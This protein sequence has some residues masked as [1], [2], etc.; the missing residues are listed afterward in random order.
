LG[1]DLSRTGAR[2][3]RE[4]LLGAV[5]RIDGGGRIGK[6]ADYSAGERTR[7]AQDEVAHGNSH[8]HNEQS[9]QHNQDSGQ[10]PGCRSRKSWSMTAA[11]TAS[12]FARARR[13][14]RPW[15]RTIASASRVE[16]RSSHSVTG[17]A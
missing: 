14:S 16:S 12:M 9:E 2:P 17:S 3:H 13:M 11:A 7:F 6:L 1:A 4:H 5:A 8:A 15:A 10:H